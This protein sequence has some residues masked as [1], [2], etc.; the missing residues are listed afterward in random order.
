MKAMVLHS[1]GIDST[2]CLAVA[3]RDFSAAEVLSV[4]VRYGQR[5]SKEMNY[6][7]ASANKMGIAHT[8][9]QA[10]EMPHSM[11]TDPSVDVPDVTYADIKGVSPTY[12]P[13]RNGVL[14]SYIA[15]LAQAQKAE[16]IYFGAHAED[17]AGDAYPDC[18]LH[19]VGSMAAAIYIGTYHQV[20]LHAP[21][22]EMLKYE[23]VALGQKLG[24]PW[25]LTWSCYKGEDLHCGA[26]PTCHARHAAFI[27]AGVDDPTIYA[28]APRA[29]TNAATS[30]R[31]YVMLNG[32][33]TLVTL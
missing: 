9:V 15:A 30:D 5:H 19:F 20:R 31:A 7:Q 23:V 22:I 26:C 2:T 24:V 16:A 21:I 12:V 1:G 4:S 28:A 3:A 14:L 13:F 11:L 33:P 18:T 8:V 29:V 10:P 27:T 6:A 17:A 25:A 32:I